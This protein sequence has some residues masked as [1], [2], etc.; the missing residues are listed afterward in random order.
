MHR[1]AAFV[2]I[3]EVLLPGHDALQ[4]LYL[5]GSAPGGL[6]PRLGRLA[7]VAATLPLI[8]L[9]GWRD[10]RLSRRLGALHLRGL[11]E[12]RVELLTLELH[13]RMLAGRVREEG[14]ALVAR[15]R[16]DGHRVVLVTTGPAEAARPLAARLEADDVLGGRLEVR[17]GIVTG[18]LLEPDRGARA[19]EWAAREGVSL[20]GSYAYGVDLA[21]LPLL[22]AVGF[23][24]AVNP[25]AAL[26]RVAEARGWPLLAI[27]R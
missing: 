23:P 1:A 15:L 10:R 14:E 26:R 3:E 27:R 7:A 8:G 6:P 19:R 16:A 12:D 17:D 21:D 9:A 11:S 5:A 24:C 4:A 20:A 13:D 22:E 18:K 25:D 2:R